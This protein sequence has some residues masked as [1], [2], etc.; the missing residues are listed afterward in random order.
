MA[1]QSRRG[2]SGG[3]FAGEDAPS[4]LVQGNLFDTK[5]R[6]RFG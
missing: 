3:H 6:C 5:G 1:A 2:R 4:G